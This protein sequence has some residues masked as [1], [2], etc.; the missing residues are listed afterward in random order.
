MSDV[1]NFLL[2]YPCACSPDGLQ[3]GDENL[4]QKPS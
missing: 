1:S 3:D 2:A 4:D